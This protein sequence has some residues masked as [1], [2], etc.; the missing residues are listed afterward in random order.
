MD[1]PAKKRSPILMVVIVALVVMVPFLAWYNSWFGRD[2]SD[3]RIS[4]ILATGTDGPE[5]QHAL[6]RIQMR[7]QKGDESATRWRS[8]IIAL[9]GHE[10][11]EVRRMVAWTLGHDPH[12]T[13]RAALKTMLGDAD[14]AARRNAAVA[15]TKWRDDAGRAV[16]LKA[17]KFIEVRAPAG[18][19][20]DLKVREGDAVTTGRD[21]AIIETKNSGDL[22]LRPPMNG[23]V[24]ELAAAEGDRITSGSI[25]GTLAPDPE[26]V[27]AALKALFLVGRAEDAA[28]IEPF[29]RGEVKYMTP[30][31]TEQARKTLEKLRGS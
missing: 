31:V 11:P 19:V 21:M 24:L 2:L 25:V 3:G 29:A 26:S 8:R 5:V 30:E 1:K 9:T 16:L 27:F 7:L 12:E 23:R 13:C 14:L 17:L 10:L 15:L 18:G 22:S 6:S 28:R 4:E 20:L